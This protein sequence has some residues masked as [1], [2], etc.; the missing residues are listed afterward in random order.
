MKTSISKLLILA[1]EDI[2]LSQKTRKRKIGI[3]ARDF[4]N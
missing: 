4:S 3:S 2:K 1:D